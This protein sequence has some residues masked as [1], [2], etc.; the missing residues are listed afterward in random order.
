[1]RSEGKL[2]TKFFVTSGKATDKISSLN[3]F[4][5]AVLK[6]GIG[7]TNIVTVSSILPEGSEEVEKQKLP[8]G[9]V[10][11]CVLARQNG[12]EGQTIS[13]GLAWTFFKNKSWGLVAEE[14][15]MTDKKRLKEMLEWKIHE[16][17]R[18]RR[19][20]LGPIN[21]KVESIRVPWYHNGCVI[22]ALVFAQ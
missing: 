12:E 17:A 18:F 9:E 19:L 2:Y 22:V 16:M 15:G 7:N 4:D 3:A 6:A 13:A 1:M 20:K 14:H 10:L 11:H 5:K 21:Y 8:I